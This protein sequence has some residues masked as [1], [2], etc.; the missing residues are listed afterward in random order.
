MAALSGKPRLRA[1]LRL[2]SGE[3]ADAVLGHQAGGE[4]SK[5]GCAAVNY[6]GDPVGCSLM[7]PEV[8]WRMAEWARPGAQ[9]DGGQGY[10]RASSA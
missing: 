8:V 1:A 7:N 2:A 9:E 3:I 10:N 4:R 5:C 6:A